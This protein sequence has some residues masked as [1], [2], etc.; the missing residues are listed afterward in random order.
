MPAT[1]LLL[2]CAL[3]WVSNIISAYAGLPSLPW[4]TIHGDTPIPDSCL[5]V[6]LVGFFTQCI[7]MHQVSK[8]T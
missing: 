4:P 7:R 2:C 8:A 1:Q 6:G 3:I 5:S